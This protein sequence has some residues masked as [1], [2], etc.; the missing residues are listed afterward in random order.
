MNLL[1]K[2]FLSFVSLL[3]IAVFVLLIYV[4]S[5][6]KIN[7][8]YEIDEHTYYQSSRS[9][10]RHKL[11]LDDYDHVANVLMNDDR[12]YATANQDQRRYYL[13]YDKEKKVT[14]S[15]SDESHDFSKIYSSFMYN[16]MYT[17]LYEYADDDESTGRILL[18]I[19]FENKK[20][21]KTELPQQLSAGKIV[22]DGQKLFGT[23]K[24]YIYL[25]DENMSL[26]RIAKGSDVVSV[27]DKLLFYVSNGKI[28]QYD[29]AAQ[30]TSFVQN[31]PNLEKYD[32]VDPDEFYTI[33]NKYFIGCTLGFVDYSDSSSLL[34]CTTVYDLSR[35]KKYWFVGNLGKVATHFQIIN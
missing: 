29:L 6:P 15:V 10:F 2:L 32:A 26:K 23:D 11:R 5:V 22:S 7:V 35:G 31:S 27:D 8:L 16:G 25:L 12:W 21:I 19:D 28:C 20:R 33:R 17:V 18:S 34:S 30:K 14:V 9:I 1:K 4:A 24:D 3:M 13:S